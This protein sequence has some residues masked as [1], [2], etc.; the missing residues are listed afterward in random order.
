M[1]IF[2]TFSNLNP[3][4]SETNLKLR[5]PN[6]GKCLIVSHLSHYLHPVTSTLWMRHL[7]CLQSQTFLCISKYTQLYLQSHV[8]YLHIEDPLL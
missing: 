5:V 7:G 8:C 6:T 2:V 4:S 1:S 3:N